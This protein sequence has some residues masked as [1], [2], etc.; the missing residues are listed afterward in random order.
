[1]FYK[2]MFYEVIGIINNICFLEIKVV[3]FSFI[4]ILYVEVCRK[5]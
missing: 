5:V 3:I 1:M 4:Y 2:R